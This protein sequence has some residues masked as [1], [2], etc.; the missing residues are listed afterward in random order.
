[1]IQTASAIELGG[2]QRK[3]TFTIAA[4]VARW[5]TILQ[6]KLV[7]RINSALLCARLLDIR[8]PVNTIW[9]EART[10]CVDQNGICGAVAHL[11][12]LRLRKAEQRIIGDV[13]RL[14]LHDNLI[15]VAACN[16]VH[17][18]RH[19][20]TICLS[21]LSC[22]F[23]RP[24]SIR[25]RPTGTLKSTFNQAPLSPHNLLQAD[26][27]YQFGNISGFLFVVL[28]RTSTTTTTSRV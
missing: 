6:V 12:Q 22:C 20:S 24:R 27:N 18:R 23:G 2:G 25:T 7:D 9:R 1:M 26:S 28:K 5:N 16:N 17:I 21:L 15:L 11:V 19:L 8:R 14:R 10:L 4:A 13:S 3:C